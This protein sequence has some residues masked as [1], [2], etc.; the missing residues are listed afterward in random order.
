MRVR[1]RRHREALVANPEDNDYVSCQNCGDEW[2]ETLDT[3]GQW[4]CESC[5]N[6]W[7]CGCETCL[8]EGKHELLVP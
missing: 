5:F 8:K 3:S 1:L 4:L 2:S 7:K 6:V